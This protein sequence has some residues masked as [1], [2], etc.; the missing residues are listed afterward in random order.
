MLSEIPERGPSI[1]LL[2]IENR[3]FAVLFYVLSL[4]HTLTFN[5][6]H[7]D[8]LQKLLFCKT[9]YLKEVLLYLYFS[10]EENHSQFQLNV[11]SVEMLFPYVT[12]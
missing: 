4:C 8:I 12:H 7:T 5:M 1:T 2:V 9:K 3:Q 6:S 10:K 11:I